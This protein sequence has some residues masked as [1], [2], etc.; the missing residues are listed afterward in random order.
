MDPLI[1][2]PI[3]SVRQES[4]SRGGGAVLLC[5]ILLLSPALLIFQPESSDNGTCE[6]EAISVS[7]TLLDA[8]IEGPA[9]TLDL[10]ASLLSD[11]FQGAEFECTD[12]GIV[13]VVYSGAGPLLSLEGANSLLPD[14]GCDPNRTRLANGMW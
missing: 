6:G 10:P 9:S 12:V 5:H 2:A 7:S 11:A 4:I 3:T 13:A 1:S 8:P 14:T